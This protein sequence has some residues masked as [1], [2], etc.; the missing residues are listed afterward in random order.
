MI[1]P[2]EK[3]KSLS[4][5]PKTVKIHLPVIELFLWPFMSKNFSTF[6]QIYKAVW[7]IFFMLLIR[8]SAM[9]CLFLLFVF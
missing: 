3:E 1:S 4:T 6:L 8:F 2:F 5:F 9:L 7:T